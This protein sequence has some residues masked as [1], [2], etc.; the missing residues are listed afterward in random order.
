MDG[1][2]L[3]YNQCLIRTAAFF[4]LLSFTLIPIAG[5]VLLKYFYDEDNANFLMW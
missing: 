5:L 2:R 1:K 3:Y 4:T